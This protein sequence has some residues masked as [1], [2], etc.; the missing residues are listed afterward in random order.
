MVLSQEPIPRHSLQIKKTYT[1]YV[2][3][4]GQIAPVDQACETEACVCSCCRF[5]FDGTVRGTKCRAEGTFSLL[6]F[7]QRV[8]NPNTSP[9]RVNSWFSSCFPHQ[10]V[11][12]FTRTRCPFSLVWWIVCY[13]VKAL[14]FNSQQIKNTQRDIWRLLS[15]SSLRDKI[16]A[17]SFSLAIA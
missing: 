12:L 16:M 1:L 10:I 2:G 11:H 3:N 6:D 8:R 7:G 9:V 15:P 17:I 4:H 13:R 14:D 5:G